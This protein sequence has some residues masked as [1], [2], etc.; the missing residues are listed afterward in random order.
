MATKKDLKN[1]LMFYF[2]C[3]VQWQPDKKSKFTFV[4]I[5][6]GGLHLK[7][8]HATGKICGVSYK[9]V[10]LVLYSVESA[11]K[12]GLFELQNDI[13]MDKKLHYKPADFQKLISLDVDLFGLIDAG[14]AIDKGITI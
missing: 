14:L 10:K 4:G 5:A 3:E 6:D 13:C 11:I 12:N 8:E 1:Y 7:H 2:G 9:T